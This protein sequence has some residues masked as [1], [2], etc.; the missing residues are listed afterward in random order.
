M[1]VVQIYRPFHARV[2]A[3]LD[4][5]REAGAGPVLVAVHSFTPVFKGKARAV[6]LG[7]LHDEDSRLADSLLDLLAQDKSCDARR[8]EP[9]GPQD[10]VTHTLNLHCVP[11][12]L[13]NVMLE[14]RNDLIANEVGQTMW[15]NRLA[16]LLGRALPVISTNQ[17]AEQG[18]AAG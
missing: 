6:E 3:V 11:H 13:H 16:M 14:I 18:V 17:P 1:L 7:V 10:G 4:G 5:K 15:A 9:Y 12:R 8:N 2:T